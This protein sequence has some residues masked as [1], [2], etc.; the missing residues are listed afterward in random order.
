MRRSPASTY[1]AI[2][3]IAALVLLQNLFSSELNVLS[4]KLPGIDKV[5]H[6]MEYILIVWCVHALA[7]RL[8]QNEGARVR[9]AV[10]AGICDSGSG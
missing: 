6:L 7:G 8:T 9:L 10:G 2:G 5:L 1:H 3:G 4:L